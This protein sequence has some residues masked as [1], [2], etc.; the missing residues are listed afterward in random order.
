MTTVTV[1]RNMLVFIKGFNRLLKTVLSKSL[2]FTL[3]SLYFALKQPD[4][5]VIF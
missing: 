1:K 3:I 4:F 2:V 5:L